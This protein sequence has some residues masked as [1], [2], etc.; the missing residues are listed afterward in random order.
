MQ[1]LKAGTL[2]SLLHHFPKTKL[3]HSSLPI[4]FNSLFISK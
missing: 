2:E 4:I 3:I 1:G